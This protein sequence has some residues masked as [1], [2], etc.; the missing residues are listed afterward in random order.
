[1]LYL[2]VVYS[3]TTHIILLYFVMNPAWPYIEY[4]VYTGDWYA[5]FQILFTFCSPLVVGVKPSKAD[6]PT[7]GKE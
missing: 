5:I 1:M 4:A 7:I 3:R 2:L 6:S